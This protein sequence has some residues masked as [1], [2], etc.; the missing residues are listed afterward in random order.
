MDSENL[1]ISDRHVR[2]LLGGPKEPAD[3]SPEEPG[4]NHGKRDEMMWQAAR[5]AHAALGL[6]EPDERDPSNTPP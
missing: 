1:G 4:P 3:R 2:R 6:D 5:M